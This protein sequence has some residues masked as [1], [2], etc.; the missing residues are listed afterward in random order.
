M[1]ILYNPPPHT[2]FAGGI[3]IIWMGKKWDS[4]MCTIFLIGKTHTLTFIFW[5]FFNANAICKKASY[6]KI[7]TG[8]KTWFE[9]SFKCLNYST[10]MRLAVIV[11]FYMCRMCIVRLGGFFLWK[12][13]VKIYYFFY[14]KYTNVR[15]WIVFSMTVALNK[16]LK[17]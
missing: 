16:L 9:F 4:W 5:V 1:W 14:Q 12:N 3:I 10:C 11:L 15:E 2:L 13:I 17:L 7:V 6:H 8:K